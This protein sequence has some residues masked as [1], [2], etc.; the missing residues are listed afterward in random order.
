[1]RMKYFDIPL[2]M[3]SRRRKCRVYLDEMKRREICANTTASY[4][5]ATYWAQSARIYP[6]SAN[7]VDS[8]KY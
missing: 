2:I 3:K 1:M 5:Q 4:K 8:A 6:Q 7:T